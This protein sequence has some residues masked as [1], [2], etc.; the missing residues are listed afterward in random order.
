VPRDSSNDLVGIG[1]PGLQTRVCLENLFTVNVNG[2]GIST[3][4]PPFSALLAQ[5]SVDL[6]G[7]MGQ[8][9]HARRTPILGGLNDVATPRGQALAQMALAW[10]LRL[11]AITSAV[12]G[13]SRVEQIE[14]NLRAVENGDFSVE[15]RARIDDLTA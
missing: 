5:S 10:I 1:E 3:S 6:A 13:A 2:F 15:E 7:K 8:G 4:W 9:P 11:P 14:Q 12:V